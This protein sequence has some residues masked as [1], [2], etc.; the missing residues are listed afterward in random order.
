MVPRMECVEC[1]AKIAMTVLHGAA[2]TMGL[3]PDCG[4]WRRIFLDAAAA[5]IR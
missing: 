3:L 1:S 5:R 2:A 4:L